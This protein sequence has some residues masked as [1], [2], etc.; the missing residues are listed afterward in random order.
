MSILETNFCCRVGEIDIVARDRNELVFVEVRLRNNTQFGSGAESVTWTKQHKLIQAAR[1]YLLTHR[2]SGIEPICRF[3]VIS[4]REPNYA[5]RARWQ[6][7][8]IA[9]AF[10]P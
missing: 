5:G 2:N 1:Y 9:D 7:Q 6:V 4:M 10:S 8:W 3:D